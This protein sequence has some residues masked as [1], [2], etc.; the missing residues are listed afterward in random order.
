MM[1]K[2]VNATS[3]SPA[4][5]DHVYSLE[6][7]GSG[8]VSSEI[9]VILQW[10][11]WSTIP[12]IVIVCGI[13]GNVINIVCF[14][15]QGFNDSVNVTFVGKWLLRINYLLYSFEIFH[16]EVTDFAIPWGF[17]AWLVSSHVKYIFLKR[18]ITKILLKHVNK[19]TPNH[20]ILQC[21]HHHH[22]FVHD[23]TSAASSTN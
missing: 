21:K 11:I 17:Y 22:V 9:T 15:R 13:V 16:A 1:L 23:S 12:Q 2:Y 4:R 14:V 3:S 6:R 18:H 10:I 5:Q 8:I 7:P 20:E 19:I